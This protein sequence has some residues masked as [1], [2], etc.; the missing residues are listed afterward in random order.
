MNTPM[1]ILMNDGGDITGRMSVNIP[2]GASERM[3][4]GSPFV[5]TGIGGGVDTFLGQ[6]D[7]EDMLREVS[8]LP[9]S[10]RAA[11]LREMKRKRRLHLTKNGEV[12]NTRKGE[13][14]ESD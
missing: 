3:G 12:R 11:A 4:G 1:Q 6:I 14:E 10:Q 5:S 2:T 13:E 8:K 7:Y 9:P